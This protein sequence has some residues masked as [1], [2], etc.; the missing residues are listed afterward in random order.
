[1]RN[2]KAITIVCFIFAMVLLFVSC[3]DKAPEET[4]KGFEETSYVLAQ[5]GKTEYTIIIPQNATEYELFA[6]DE[7]QRLFLEATGADLPIKSDEDVHFSESAKYISISDTVVQKESGVNPDFATYKRSGTRLVN[8][9]SCMILTGA[10]EEGS[11]YAV[12]DFLG[13]LFDYEYFDVDAYRLNKKTTVKLPAL[14]LSNIPDYDYRM[15]GDHL[16]D[17]ATGGDKHHAWRQRYKVYGEGYAIDG[18]AVMSILPPST[19]YAEHPDWYSVETGMLGSNVVRQLCYTNEEMTAQFIEN[20]KAYLRKSPDAWCISIAQ[21]D[22]NVWCHCSNCTAAMK[23]Y[24]LSQYGQGSDDLGAVTQILFVNKVVSAIEEW[25]ETEFPGRQLSYMILAYH[26]TINPPAHLDEA[27]GKYIANGTERGDNS[28]VLPA[29]VM[30]QYAD[31]FADRNVSYRDNPTV[32]ANLRAWAACA[33]GLY[34]YEYPQDAYHVCLPYDGLHVFG[35]NIAFGN[36]L[37]INSYFMQGNFNTQSSGFTPLKVY[38]ASKLMWDSS[39]DVNKLVEDYMTYCY[40]PAADTM[41]EYYVTLRS[42]LAY[43]RQANGYGATCLGNYLSETNWPRYLMLEYQTLFDRAYEDIDFLRQVDE[44]QY[45][46]IFRKIKIEEMFICY[47]NCSLYRGYYSEEEKSAMIDEF[48]YYAR[49]YDF[50]NHN[51]TQP[52]SDLLKLWRES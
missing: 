8:K 18:H 35:D 15:Y 5:D 16:S 49:K 2:I 40:G 44:E 31:I 50:K 13:I 32:S 33:P 29:N 26:Q 28:M 17:E 34:V 14:D 9:G 22:V 30:V 38:V 45:E 24:G 3:G 27:S 10:A 52:M 25:M 42:R 20:L 1:M 39:L 7:L 6:A 43:L 37:G 46:I 41:M 19:Y 11:L 23:Q 51:E 36:E 4:E 47:V 48:E 12:Y 21:E